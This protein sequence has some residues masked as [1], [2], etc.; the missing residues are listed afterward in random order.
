MGGVIR[1]IDDGRR[2]CCCD[3]LILSSQYIQI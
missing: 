2:R 3:G 1:A